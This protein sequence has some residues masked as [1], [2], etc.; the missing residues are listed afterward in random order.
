MKVV[1]DVFLKEKRLGT[2]VSAFYG[3]P[4]PGL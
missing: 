2:S 3:A 1:K 4:T